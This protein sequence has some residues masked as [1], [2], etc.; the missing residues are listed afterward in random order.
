MGI[1]D[2]I[3]HPHSE[4]LLYVGYDTIIKA[5]CSH[6]KI[7][8]KTELIVLLGGQANAILNVKFLGSKV[9]FIVLQKICPHVGKFLS[10]MPTSTSVVHLGLEQKTFFFSSKP[11][12]SFLTNELEG[13]P[14]G[15]LL[16]SC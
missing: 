15:F 11:H 7:F 4:L 2:K 6:N 8:R 13:A 3:S 9:G 5:G 14:R 12:L 1:S 10:E 16:R